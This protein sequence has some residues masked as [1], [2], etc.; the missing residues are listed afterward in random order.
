MLGGGPAIQLPEKPLILLILAGHLPRD[1]LFQFWPEYVQLPVSSLTDLSPLSVADLSQELSDAVS[2]VHAG[3]AWQYINIVVFQRTL[4]D[5][6]AGGQGGGPS[7]ATRQ[8]TVIQIAFYYYIL[9]ELY[10]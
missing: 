6:A 5:S 1:Q 10:T 8:K 3:R 9:S 2:V 4:Q 7:A